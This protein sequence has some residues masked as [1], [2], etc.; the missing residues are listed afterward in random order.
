MDKKALL[1]MPKLLA[2][3]TMLRVAKENQPK[4]VIVHRW[5]CD[6][7]EIQCR[8]R[9][10]LRCAEQDKILKVALF[11]P[12][13]LWGGGRKPIFEL[14][15]DKK[16][17]TFLTY[18]PLQEK[19]L[20]SKLDR[21]EWPGMRYDGESWI[22]DADAKRVRAYLNNQTSR[23]AYSAILR[24]QLDVR[25][26][27]L[28]RRHEKETS[29]WDLV[30]EQIRPLPKD[31]ARWVDKVGIP[32]QFM[33]YEYKP[34]GA[35]TGYCSYCEKDVP[36]RNP[37]YN[38]KGRCPCCRREVTYKSI[39]R[40]GFLDTKNYFVYL[41]QKVD[42]GFV[43]RMFEAWR[44]QSRGEYKSPTVCC[45]EIR[46]AF[47][48]AQGTPISAYYW[49]VYKQTKL[50]WIEGNLCGTS[51]WSI[52]AGRV[53]GKTLQSLERSGLNR[54]G[55]PEYIRSCERVD[56]ELYLAVL[57]KVPQLEQLMKASLPALANECILHSYD[58][59][60]FFN[61]RTGSLRHML[62]INSQELKRLRASGAGL[63]FLTWLKVEHDY[64]R[65]ISNETIKW[66]ISKSIDP[67][68][69]LFI[70]DRMTVEQVCNYIR[71][72]MEKSSI[73][74]DEVIRLW[75]DYLSMAERLGHN[76]NDEIVYRTSKLRKRHDDLVEVFRREE[77]SIRA[78]ELQAK[79]PGVDSICATLLPKY[80]FAGETY[81]VVAP[82]GIADI[83]R[84]GDILHHCIASSDRYLERMEQHESYILF[85]RRTKAEGEPYY[86]MEV[87]PNGTV[88]QIRTEY[89]RQNKD[90]RKI[91]EFLRAWQLEL[92]KR[93][94]EEDRKRAQK[95]GAL[96]V[97]EFAE[98]RKDQVKVRTGELAG[99][100]LVDV[101]AADLMEAA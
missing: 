83:L 71:A 50:R 101:L 57:N 36:I 82:T 87:E 65:P 27:E 17:D 49:G 18:D 86:S 45:R 76:V 34:G 88:R 79:F 28:K 37:R 35:K 84:E 7:E 63:K 2:T 15:I 72:Q 78:R 38:K 64:E 55:L 53:Y 68:K 61:G 24:F 75:R 23:T 97:Q 42:C 69:I 89:D 13:V 14:Y 43:I 94:T 11:Q 100:L 74:A 30:M 6:R 81:S 21:L 9:L 19:W 67:Q 48:N 90:I 8:Y 16:N 54:T 60:S 12:E 5:G 77:R 96:R 41:L 29:A 52:P 92:S 33:Y 59:S 98:L 25:E 32:E 95:S 51:F 3:P 80:S 46:R 99:K 70:L 47:F 62:G 31:W 91:R 4:K 66:F 93:L 58:Y 56:P 73:G 44:R 22:S 26:Q 1:A 10:Y 39:R 85:L 20:A 40:V